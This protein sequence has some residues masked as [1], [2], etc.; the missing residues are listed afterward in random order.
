MGRT[1][2]VPRS[3]KGESRILYIFTVKSLIS[4]IL[5][6]GIGF[7]P[8]SL[9]ANIGMKTAGIIILVV[10]AIIGYGIMSLKI[11]DSP[12]MG[13]FR[14]AGGEQLSDILFRSITFVKRKKIYLYRKGGKKQWEK[15]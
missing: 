9:L 3:V 4:T 12:I 10:F 7:I 2:G 14:R 13:S 6:A 5:F 15:K 8:Y 11:P 1:Y